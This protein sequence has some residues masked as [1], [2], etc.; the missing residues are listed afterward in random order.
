MSVAASLLKGSRIASA[1]RRI[2]VVLDKNQFTFE[3][4]HELVLVRVP[5]A[6]AGPFARRQSGEVHAEICQA[7]SVAELLTQP[8]GGEVGERLWIT[9]AL[10]HWY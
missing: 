3:D 4:E 10:A 2:A 9:D 1:E 7:A 6:L 8:M 5:V